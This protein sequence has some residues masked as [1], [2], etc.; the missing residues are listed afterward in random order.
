MASKTIVMSLK[1][2]KGNLFLLQRVENRSL[3]RIVGRQFNEAAIHPRYGYGVVEED[4]SWVAWVNQIFLPAGLGENCDLG[5]NWHIQ[6]SQHRT[7]VA[8]RSFEL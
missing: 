3:M 2:R 4:R 1:C 7:K 8:L 6:C 5:L